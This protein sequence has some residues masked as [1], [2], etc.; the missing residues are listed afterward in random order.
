VGNPRT[1]PRRPRRVS[2]ANKKVEEDTFID[3]HG[4]ER[5]VLHYYVDEK[6]LKVFYEI[7][8]KLN[9]KWRRKRLTAT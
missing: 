3:E 8:G 7:L 1:R 2:M 6:E 5:G 9:L 4:P